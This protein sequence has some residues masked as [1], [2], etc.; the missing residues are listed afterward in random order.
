MKVLFVNEYTLRYGGVDRIVDAEVSALRNI[1]IDVTVFSIHHKNFITA[2]AKLDYLRILKSYF[3]AASNLQKEIDIQKPDIVHFH[4]I[5]PILGM[6][7]WNK[8]KKRKSKFI[9]HLHNYYP[10]CINSFFFRK[11]NICTLCRDSNS[12][13]PGIIHKCYDNSFI[14]SCVVSLIKLSPVGW[15]KE[16]TQIDHLV[17]VSNFICNKYSDLGIDKEK[18]SCIYNFSDHFSDDQFALGDYVL[19]LGDVVDAKGIEIICEAALRL[20]LIN[21][22]IAGDGREFHKYNSAYINAGNIKF[23]GYV[24][25]QEKSKLILNCRFLL[26]PFLSWESFGLIILE[27]YNYGKPVITSGRGGSQELVVGGKTGIIL[28]KI[29]YDF[30]SNEVNRFWK[31]LESSNSYFDDCK[32]YSAKFNID[33]HIEKLLEIYRKCTDE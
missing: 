30:V 13:T 2:K 7:I 12:I 18:V 4:N 10:F 14:N 26:L 19:Y 29:D 16:S 31:Q 27:A 28:Q 15:I 5:Y 6:P 23:I 24:D 20:P 21:F 22:I 33:T 1:N 8:I 25:G 9:L 3:N 17:G 32:E 11:G